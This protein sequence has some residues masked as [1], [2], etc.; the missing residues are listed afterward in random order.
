MD[1]LP[2]IN[3]P[4]LVTAITVP[5]TAFIET[6]TISDVNSIQTRKRQN[7]SEKPNKPQNTSNLTNSKK[8]PV[9]TSAAINNTNIN[10]ISTST[11]N[12][13]Y[14]NNCSGL[15]NACTTSGRK[16]S[17]FD[18][19]LKYELKSTDTI[20]GQFG[21]ITLVSSRLDPLLAMKK[22]DL[23]V[24]NDEKV[25]SYLQK[26]IEQSHRGSQFSYQQ[27]EQELVRLKA[28]EYERIVKFL[29]LLLGMNRCFFG[30]MFFFD[31]WVTKKNLKY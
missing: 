11:I 2:K 21:Q 28:V 5:K 13:N 7:T 16:L 26:K 8:L 25:L 3:S 6:D 17:T 4:K 14:N 15:A 18:P 31:E 27:A 20:A 24:I 23:A 30:K 10:T 1:T 19:Y 9:T 29:K 22:V 12:N